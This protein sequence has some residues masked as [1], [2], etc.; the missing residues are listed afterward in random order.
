MNTEWCL[1]A[2]SKAP[3]LPREQNFFPS[4][5]KTHPLKCTTSQDSWEPGFSLLSSQQ[6]R[7]LLSANTRDSFDKHLYTERFRI[8]IPLYVFNVFS[9]I[10]FKLMCNIC[11]ASL[12]ELAVTMG[13]ISHYVCIGDGTS[14]IENICTKFQLHCGI[15]KF[16]Y[17]TRNVRSDASVV[18]SITRLPRAPL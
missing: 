15:T 8:S 16:I 13:T 17:S 5:C 11:Q 7:L 18:V 14:V 9:I 1:S 2:C 3:P 6:Y 10:S 12:Y 4:I